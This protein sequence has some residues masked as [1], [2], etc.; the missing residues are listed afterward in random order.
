MV[1]LSMVGLFALLNVDVNRYKSDITTAITQQTGLVTTFDGPI[2]MK[3]LPMPKFEAQKMSATMGEGKSKVVISAQSVD[4]E[5]DFVMFFKKVVKINAFDLKG[6]TIETSGSNAQKQAFER[7]QGQLEYTQGNF[8]LKNF[9]VKHKL[10]DFSGHLNVVKDLRTKITGELTAPSINLSNGKAKPNQKLFSTEPIPLRWMEPINLDVKVS[11]KK[12][13]LDKIELNNVKMQMKHQKGVF[14]FTQ[15]AI[16]A[17]GNYNMDL[18]I[19]DVTKASPQAN[20]KVNLTGADAA[21]VLKKI[22][23]KIAASGGKMRFELSGSGPISDMNNLVTHL[24]GKS[25]VDIRNMHL[26]KALGSGG[27]SISDSLFNVLALPTRSKRQEILECAVA[28]VNI[29]N[30]VIKA[31]NRLGFETS[32]LIGLGS[33]QVNLKNEALMLSFNFEPKKNL[34]FSIG[35]FEN[36]AE[37]GGTI[38]QPKVQLN[39]LGAIQEGASLLLGI[40]TMGLSVV[41]KNLLEMSKIGGSP[42]QSVLSSN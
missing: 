17:K 41:A 31:D 42:C 25:L 22:N 16:L 21:T 6:V 34:P 23:P 27:M 12:L 10:G 4:I 35:D 11:T 24:N 15:N 18:T 39:T 19:K 37:I 20:V 30:G 9:L 26:D 33:G 7:M 29:Q 28:K 3:L 2:G 8:Q 14:H 40:S 5:Y 13:L 38:R 1:I 36:F 32:S